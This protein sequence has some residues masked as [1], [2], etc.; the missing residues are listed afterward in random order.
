MSPVFMLAKQLNIVYHRLPL[1]MWNL[2]LFLEFDVCYP[3][4]R[5]ESNKTWQTQEIGFF[6][7]ARKYSE[8]VSACVFLNPSRRSVMLWVMLP[9]SQQQFLDETP[10]ALLA[11]NWVPDIAMIQEFAPFGV[12]YGAANISRS[13]GVDNAINSIFKMG[14]GPCPLFRRGGILMI[15]HLLF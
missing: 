5:Y 13:A 3:F 6:A 12:S 4:I 14:F 8:C 9:S 15:S 1:D 2:Q 11:S 10:E 7:S